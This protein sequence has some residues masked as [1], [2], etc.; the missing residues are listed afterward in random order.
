MRQQAEEKTAASATARAAAEAEAEAL[1]RGPGSALDVDMSEEEA[2]QEGDA[3]AHQE[4][5]SKDEEDGSSSSDEGV[6]GSGVA[7]KPRAN[8]VSN[9]RGHQSSPMNPRRSHRLKSS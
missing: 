2:P 4:Q 3:V 1:L 6:H 5:G 9:K 8:Q 7:T